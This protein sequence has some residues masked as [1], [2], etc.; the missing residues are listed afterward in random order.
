MST[1]SIGRNLF[2]SRSRGMGSRLGSGG[3]AEYRDPEREVRR[4]HVRLAVAGALVL[5]A[6]GVLFARFVYL[7]VIRPRCMC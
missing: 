5:V 3:L 2:T 7:Q 1:G 4:F 6:F